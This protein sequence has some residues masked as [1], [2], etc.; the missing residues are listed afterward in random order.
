M[1][2]CVCVCVCVEVTKLKAFADD[3]LNI[4]KI[5]ISL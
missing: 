2:V 3:K 4:I 5:A 1:C